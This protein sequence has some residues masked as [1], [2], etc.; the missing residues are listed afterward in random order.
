MDEATRNLVRQRA[1]SCC[2]YCGLSQDQSPLAS[3][4]IE[5]ILPR[6]HG[7]SDAADNLALACIDRNLHKGSNIAGIDPQTGALTEL[8]HPRRHQWS[9]HLEWHG[10]WIAGKTPIGR[11]TVQVLQ[12]NNEDRVELRI[13]SRR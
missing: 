6:K 1:G 8:F 13:A 11:A 5:H 7:G 9:V 10:P 3:L 12:L 2:E 4:H